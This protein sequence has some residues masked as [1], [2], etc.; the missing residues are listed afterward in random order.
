MRR[1]KG[2]RSD[3]RGSTLVELLAIT[4][5]IGILAAI[6][7]PSML[8]HRDRGHHAAAKADLRN[9]VMAEHAYRADHAEW[10]TDPRLLEQEGYRASANV[11]PVHVRLDGDAFVAC[12][13]HQA[14]GSWL[15]YDSRTAVVTETE[16]GCT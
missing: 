4:G 15:L 3:D 7:L 5:I 11:T 8:V 10:A 13:K 16:S 12:L 1:N 2:N 9:A 6:A 14:M